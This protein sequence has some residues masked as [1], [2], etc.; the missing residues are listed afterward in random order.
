MIRQAHE[1]P[2]GMDEGA[3]IMSGLKPAR[4]LEAIDMSVAHYAHEE[5]PFRVA[6]DYEAE[7]VSLK[8][9]RTIVSYTDYVNRTV[10]RK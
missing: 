2:E 7:N 4:V 6:R 10:W 3:V 5:R 8:V 9:V 1:R